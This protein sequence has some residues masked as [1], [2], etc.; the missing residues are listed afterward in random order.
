MS[1]TDF[2][3]RFS[4]KS[5]KVQLYFLSFFQGG[6]IMK[7]WP[8]PLS[9]EVPAGYPDLSKHNNWMAKCMTPRSYGMMKDRK[10]KGDHKKNADIFIFFM[11]QDLY[12]L[13]EIV[14]FY[15]YV[16]KLLCLFLT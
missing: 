12:F 9:N 3:I 16:V 15:Y 13:W 2:F 7:H 4:L 6:D 10:T 5:A 1:N 11:L 8:K 14:V